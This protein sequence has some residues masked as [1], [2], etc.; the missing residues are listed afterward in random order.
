MRTPLTRRA[1]RRVPI[2][3]LL[4]AAVLLPTLSLAPA[5]AAPKDDTTVTS[6][7]KAQ[8]DR[9]SKAAFARIKAGGTRQLR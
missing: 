6:A 4:A 8:A 9:D 3:A 5:I 2:R 1:L 7:M